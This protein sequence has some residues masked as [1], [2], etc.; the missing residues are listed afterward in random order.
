[1]GAKNTIF[2]GLEIK[3]QVLIN[4]NYPNEKPK[5]KCLTP[6]KSHPAINEQ[7]EM[8]ISGPQVSINNAFYYHDNRF[9]Q[10]IF[11]TS[12][13][14]SVSHCFSVFNVYIKD[15]D[16]KFDKVEFLKEKNC[17]LALLE[18]KRLAYFPLD[19]Q[20][21]IHM[22]YLLFYHLRKNSS[23]KVGWKIFR[24]FPKVNLF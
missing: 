21:S 24:N 18:P 11:Y 8:C 20:K 22:V 3:A 23:N 1:M 4:K 10:T 2:Y 12:L 13:I 19:A 9:M 7:G 6:I 15:S 16:T 17:F 5:I 14:S